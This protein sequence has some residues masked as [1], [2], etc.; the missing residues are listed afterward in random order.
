MFALHRDGHRTTVEPTKTT[1]E[2][3]VEATVAWYAGAIL[4]RGL[5]EQQH[6]N[7]GPPS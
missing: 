6:W 3:W 5:E 7:L 1:A 2:D 4:K